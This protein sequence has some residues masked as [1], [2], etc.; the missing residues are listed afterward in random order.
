MVVPEVPEDP[1]LEKIVV[2]QQKLQY[3]LPWLPPPGL[4]QYQ[5]PSCK[6][7]IRKVSEQGV[8]PL[9]GA[10]DSGEVR[11]RKRQ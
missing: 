4:H 3:L 7:R 11:H 1:A 9:G 2:A 6:G 8:V 10:C 5:L